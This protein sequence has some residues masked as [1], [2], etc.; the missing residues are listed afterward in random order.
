MVLH[1]PD[2]NQ[3]IFKGV[4]IISK[5]PLISIMKA[6]RLLFRGCAGYLARIVD[7]SV[8]QKLKPKDVPVVQDFLDVFLD[9]LPGLPPDEL[10]PGTAPI[11]MTPHQIA[12]VELKELK[13]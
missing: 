1:P 10:A 11:S 3:F 12:L 4:Q 6:Q 13:T 9:Y 5:F 8:E 2:T 7:V